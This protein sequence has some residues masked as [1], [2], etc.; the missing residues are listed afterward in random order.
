[1]YICAR[2]PGLLVGLLSSC[3]VDGRSTTAMS[4]GLLSVWRLGPDRLRNGGRCAGGRRE[5]ARRL[6]IK[7]RDTKCNECSNAIVLYNDMTM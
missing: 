7:I 3:G 2:A 6:D 1:M 5:A 4:R